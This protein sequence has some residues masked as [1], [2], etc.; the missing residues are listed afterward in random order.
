MRSPTRFSWVQGAGSG[1]TTDTN[2]FLTTDT[3]FFPYAD[4]EVGDEASAMQD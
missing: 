1:M 3:N 4:F 2:F